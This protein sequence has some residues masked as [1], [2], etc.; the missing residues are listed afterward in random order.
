MRGSGPDPSRL[1]PP[2]TP[3]ARD[4]V[5]ACAELDPMVIEH[6]YRSYIFG[7]ALGAAEGLECDEEALFAAAMFHDYAFAEMDKLTDCC[8]TY[9]GAESAAEF[10]EGSPLSAELRHDVLDAITLHF[11][12][13]VPPEQGAIQHLA[14]DGIL[15]DVLG[16]RAWELDPDGVSRV[17]ERHPRHGFTVRGLPLL[18]AHAA[19][20]K[21]C[22]VGAALLAGFGPALRISPWHAADAR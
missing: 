11:N 22:R 9:A 3:F 4:V 20:V 10:L 17:A 6:S 13:A 7:R 12:P 5:A 19:R 14:H 15:L 2:D 16:V 18:K 1:T 21:G 8:F